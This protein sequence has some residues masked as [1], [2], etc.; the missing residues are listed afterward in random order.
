[1]APL[2]LGLRFDGVGGGRLRQPMEERLPDSS[3]LLRVQSKMNHA[4]FELVVW[5]EVRLFA[6]MIVEE[7][8]AVKANEVADQAAIG[9]IGRSFDDEIG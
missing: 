6:A 1:M 2:I 3:R 8:F 4:D 5:R 9:V 7:S